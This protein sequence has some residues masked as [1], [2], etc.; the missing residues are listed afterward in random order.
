MFPVFQPS[1]VEYR[2]FTPLRSHAVVFPFRSDAERE[3]M[4]KAE[5]PFADSVQLQGIDALGGKTRSYRL[6]TRRLHAQADSGLARIWAA[7]P[8]RI[9]EASETD[10]GMRYGILTKGTYLGAGVQD[11]TFYQGGGSPIG[12]LPKFFHISSVSGISLE[13]GF[14]RIAPSGLGGSWG[15]AP[16]LEAYDMRGRLLLRIGLARYRIGNGFAVPMADLA[17]L[18]HSRLFFLLRGNGRSQSFS[19][20]PGAL[21]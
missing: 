7:D 16:M 8:D 2:A 17:K 19:L 9:A 15:G 5:G 21:Q 14:L 4:I 3:S 6:D 20:N 10:L 18:G 1:S 11:A 13:R 12:I